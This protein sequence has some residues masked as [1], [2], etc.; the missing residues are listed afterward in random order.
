MKN[1]EKIK[2]NETNKSFPSEVLEL[3]KNDLNILME[4]N[5]L[6]E[7]IMPSEDIREDIAWKENNGLI[8]PSH[9]D[10]YLS[11]PRETDEKE[12]TITFHLKRANEREE[13][14]GC[15]KHSDEFGPAVY[16]E[17]VLEDSLQWMTIN[18]I[19]DFSIEMEIYK[20]IQSFIK[21]NI[22]KD[23]IHFVDQLEIGSRIVEYTIKIEGMAYTYLDMGLKE[24]LSRYIERFFAKMK[25]LSLQII[26][27]NAISYL[28][29]D[30][31]RDVLE[32]IPEFN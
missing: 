28:E 2:K 22:M 8:I 11:W 24:N 15:L 32:Y 3:T 16:F 25:A 7:I 19:P 5:N 18:L 21:N 14:W 29:L 6:K 31:D 4:Q 20:E 12:L 13:Y 9:K 30:F 10:N 1:F 23:C 17:N 26:L 27:R